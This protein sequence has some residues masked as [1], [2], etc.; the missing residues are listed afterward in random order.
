MSDMATVFERHRITVDEYHR[1]GEAGVFDPD[2]RIELIDG[3]LIKMPPI[4]PPHAS[5]VDRILYQFFTRLAGRARVRCQHPVTLPPHSEP[6]PDLVLA[7]PDS[8]DYYDHHPAAQE[9]LLAV[10]VAD[11]TLKLDRRVK[12]PL[13]ARSGVA[14]VWLVNL[15]D[16]ELVSYRE[17]SDAWYGSV[18]TYRRGDS[19]SPL[20]FPDVA[21]AVEDLLPP[22]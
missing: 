2:L 20:A 4:Y 21:F 6:Q 14:E 3:E 22:A 13:Y 10:E 17:P 15:V 16:D 12:I 8:R 1:M 7:R 18:R 19:I 9:T 5:T 11:S